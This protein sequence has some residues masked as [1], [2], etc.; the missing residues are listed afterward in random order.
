MREGINFSNRSEELA[1]GT[2]IS[3]YNWSDYE[4]AMAENSGEDEAL[5]TTVTAEEMK[6]LHKIG[7][8]ICCD[9]R[10]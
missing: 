5:K 3:P 2:V 8:G 1:D 9:G 6:N 10:S 4:D 7:E